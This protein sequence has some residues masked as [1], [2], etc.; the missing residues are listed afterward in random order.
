MYFLHC[1]FNPDLSINA[2]PFLL[3]H[4]HSLLSIN[5]NTSAFCIGGI[6]TA[7]AQYLNLQERLDELP[8]WQAEFLDIDYFQCDC[9][10]KKGLKVQ[11][12]GAQ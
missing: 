6:V 9:Q 11:P 10:S 2:A 12:D 8:Y 5:I 3:N 4:I 1:T 7:I